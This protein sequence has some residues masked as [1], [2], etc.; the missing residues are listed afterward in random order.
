M[1]QV[2]IRKGYKHRMLPDDYDPKTLPS[3]APGLEAKEGDVIEVTEDELESFGDKFE[4]L[5]SPPKRRGRP[6][7]AKAAPTAEAEDESQD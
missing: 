7:K 1:L 2:K 6:R 5:E 4:V 3:G